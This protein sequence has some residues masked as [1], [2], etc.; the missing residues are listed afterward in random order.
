LHIHST[1][2]ARRIPNHAAGGRGAIDRSPGE[3]RI[4]NRASTEPAPTSI[5]KRQPY[6]RR[7]PTNDRR[8][9]KI[10]G[11]K[12]GSSAVGTAGAPPTSN[13]PTAEK[14]GSSPSAEK[15]AYNTSRSCD[16]PKFTLPVNP[17]DALPLSVLSHHTMA[18]PC[19]VRNPVRTAVESKMSWLPPAARTHVLKVHQSMRSFRENK[20]RHGPDHKHAMVTPTCLKSGC[21]ALNTSKKSPRPQRGMLPRNLT[22]IAAISQPLHHCLGIASK[23]S[24]T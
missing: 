2:P 3:R 19:T 8:L 17:E 14:D 16:A 18:V 21:D 5:H 11:S 13:V 9:Y 1:Y 15:M 20:S 24:L 7:R 10:C 22:G 23:C 4:P 12:S 6:D